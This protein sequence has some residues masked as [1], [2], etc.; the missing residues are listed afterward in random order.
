MISTPGTLP[1]P[2]VDTVDR[3]LR[4]GLVILPN[5]F[6]RLRRDPSVGGILLE[7]DKLVAGAPMVQVRLA[8][9]QVKWLPY[10]ALEP[11]PSAPETLVDRFAGGKFV[12]PDWLR[13]TLTR[14]RVTGRLSD[15]V[16]SME[17]TE[18]DFYAYQFKPVI[19]LMSSP[20]DSMLVAD[21]VGLGKTI[22]AGLVWTELRARL[23][24]DRLLVACPKTLCQKWQDELSRRFGVDAQIGDADELLGALRR[25]QDTGRG[26]A[27]VCSMQGLRPPRGWDDDPEEGE[28]TVRSTRHELARFLDE[29]SHG[30]PLIDLLVVDEAHHMRNP[31]TLL[32][33][34]GR[35]A[36]AVSGHRLFLSATPIHL[37][38]RDL[39]SV[40]AM[41]D[42]DTFEFEGTLEELIETNAPVIAARDLLLRPDSPVADIEALLDDAQAHDILRAS[43]ALAQIRHELTTTSLDSSKRSELAARIE[44]VNQLANYVTRTHAGTAHLAFVVRYVQ[45]WLRANRSDHFR[46]RRPVW[47]VNVGIP[48][49]SYDDLR[50]FKSY[51]RIAAAALQL[52]KIDAPVTLEAVK[53]FLDDPHVV[54]AADSDDAAE[55]LGVAVFP[56]AAAEMTGFAKSSR[57][58]PGLYLLVDVGAMT[59][60]VCMFRLNRQVS[61]ADRYAFMAADVRPLGVDAFHWFLAGGKTQSGFIEQCRHTLNKV[62]RRTKRER[63]PHAETWKPG[64]DVP[65][66]LAG[67]GAAHRLHQDV[68]ESVGTWLKRDVRNDGIRRLELPVPAAIDLPESLAD[69][70]RMA[71]AWG[72]SYPPTDIGRI[73]AMRDID[74]IGPPRVVDS[75]DRFVSKD[76][77]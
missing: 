2:D 74:D 47:F 67:G 40:L 65:V 27:L 46:G 6:V 49:A 59:L 58:A 57:N 24:C 64:N 45:G 30:E 70:G 71:V 25:T 11:V 68:V 31:E 69:F 37:R 72:L 76:H 62:V 5:T 33:R 39:H 53:L 55:T 32:N 34:F 73:D 7:G 21:E 60:D 23:D 63:D 41:V 19:K 51:R 54:E 77:V 29:A 38:N 56:E 16:Y 75:A 61:Q 8:D 17:A 28:D 9:G 14:L 15:V 26:F 43:Q 22:E 1:S 36:T 52:A 20:T 13:R 42:P 35:L 10:S 66:F 18:T 12:E 48:T 44:R 3:T 50:I 4:G